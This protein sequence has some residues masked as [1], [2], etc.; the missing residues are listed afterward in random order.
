MGNSAKPA[1]AS[2]FRQSV[3]ARLKSRARVLGPPTTA[4]LLRRRFLHERFLARVFAVPDGHWALKGGVGLLVRFPPRARFSRDIDLLHLSDDVDEAVA[5][6]RQAAQR[7]AGDFLRF[8]VGEPQ[9][10][11]TADGF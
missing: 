3:D 2:G 4:S 11:S 1:S 5:D 9:Q 10:V 8:Q 6:L 7:D